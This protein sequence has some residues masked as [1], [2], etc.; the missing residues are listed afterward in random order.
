M[1]KKRKKGKGRIHGYL[2]GLEAT[3]ISPGG[4]RCRKR[5]ARRKI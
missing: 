4:K 5:E 3:E 2:A 1:E